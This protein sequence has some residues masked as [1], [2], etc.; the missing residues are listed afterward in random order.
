VNGWISLGVV[1]RH[2]GRLARALALGNVLWQGDR[3]LCRS[4]RGLA[5]RR[6]TR[7]DLDLKDKGVWP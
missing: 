7:F 2:K 3:L 4:R 5:K 1:P 6:F